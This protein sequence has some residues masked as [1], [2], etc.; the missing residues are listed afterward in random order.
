MDPGQRAEEVEGGKTGNESAFRVLQKGVKM[1][2]TK[3][4]PFFSVGFLGT[5]RKNQFLSF[6][7]LNINNVMCWWRHTQSNVGVDTGAS[8]IYLF[9]FLSPS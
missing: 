9:F 8:K 5:E 6:Y 4:K 7:A 1:Q 3:I 2:L